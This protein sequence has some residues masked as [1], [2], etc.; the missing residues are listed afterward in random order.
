MERTAIQDPYTNIEKAIHRKPVAN[1]KLNGEK[2]E[3]IPLKLGTK[4]AHSF[5][6]IQFTDH[7]K[8]KNMQDQCVDSSVLLRR[9]GILTGT[10]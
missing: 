7:M 4:A 8:L 6:N 5:H 3:A 9:G 10:I 2:L 1:I